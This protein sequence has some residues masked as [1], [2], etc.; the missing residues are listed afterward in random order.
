MMKP[1]FLGLFGKIRENL[2]AE[3]A[4]CTTAKLSLITFTSLFDKGGVFRTIAALVHVRCG[5]QRIDA[6]T[7][8]FLNLGV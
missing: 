4:H 2:E 6:A 7:K 1:V 8:C 5:I 3:M